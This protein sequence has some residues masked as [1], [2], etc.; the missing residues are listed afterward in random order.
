MLSSSKKVN[1]YV[2]KLAS[3][4]TMVEA[5]EQATDYS[6]VFDS[7]SRVHCVSF[8]ELKMGSSLSYDNLGQQFKLLSKHLEERTQRNLVYGLLCTPSVGHVLHV[9]R[10]EE[11]DFSYAHTEQLSWEN[12]KDKLL[13]P[14]LGTNAE[15][16]YVKSTYG[17]YV[18]DLL[19]GGGASAS[20]FSCNGEPDIVLKVFKDD[21]SASFEREKEVLNH[22]EL[23]TQRPKGLPTLVNW[24][25]HESYLALKPRGKLVDE[26]DNGHVRQLATLLIEVNKKTGFVHRDVRRSNIIV[27]GNDVY[28]FDW[29]FAVNQEGKHVFAGSGSTAS[30]AVLQQL[31]QGYEVQYTLKD[32][33]E[34]LMKTYWIVNHMGP[35]DSGIFKGLGQMEVTTEKNASRLKFWKR[36]EEEHVRFKDLMEQCRKVTEGEDDMREWVKE[37][38]E[39]LNGEG[40]TSSFSS[41]S[42]SST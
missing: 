32:D 37:L 24:G 25:D 16:G 12:D 17:N 18:A 11:G 30:N 1:K 34:S 4:L 31:G 14:I 6:S 41:S 40:T 8:V 29:A 19:L 15:L 3:D 36:M 21:M 26:F 5:G 9:R 20:V 42:S 35:K 28:L 13:F 22:R 10:T 39:L 33:L 27:S 2:M 7:S 38:W 23:K